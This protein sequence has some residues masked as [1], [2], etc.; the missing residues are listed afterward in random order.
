MPRP[1]LPDRELVACLAESSSSRRGL[2]AGTVHQVA[3]DVI[4]R[5]EKVFLLADRK[6]SSVVE[7]SSRKLATQSQALRREMDVLTLNCALAQF[8][9]IA[10]S[11]GR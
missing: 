3:D 5:S 4:M 10:S 1:E 7:L 11:L 9:G 6:T 8:A 2:G